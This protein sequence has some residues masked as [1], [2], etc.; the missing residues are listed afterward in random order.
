M[1]PRPQDESSDDSTLISSQTS[2]LTRSVEPPPRYATLRAAQSTLDRY[3]L[4]YRFIIIFD[5]YICC[6]FSYIAFKYALRLPEALTKWRNRVK[7]HFPLPCLC[8]ST[9]NIKVTSG[10]QRLCPIFQKLVCTRMYIWRQQIYRK[11]RFIF[12]SITYSIN[13][14]FLKLWAFLLI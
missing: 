1:N 7:S 12:P 13:E 9:K 10:G 6:V 4:L 11:K 5:L 14:I 2:T 3:V 8:R